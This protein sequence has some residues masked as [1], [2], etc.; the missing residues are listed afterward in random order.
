MG[1]NKRGVVYIKKKHSIWAGVLIGIGGCANLYSPIKLLGAT[2]FSIGLITVMIENCSLYTGKIGFLRHKSEILILA[3][4]LLGNII[5]ALLIGQL[6][7]PLLFQKANEIMI[8]KL[9]VSWTIWIIR[10]IMCGILIYIAVDM[11]NKYKSL[12]VIVLPVVVFVMCGFEHCIANVFYLSVSKIVSFQSIG[13]IIT[14]IIGNTIGSLIAAVLQNT[15]RK[16]C[17]EI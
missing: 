9:S 10:S 12:L 15:V 5:G 2:L 4:M 6:L 17:N 8:Q 13:F 7:S 14:C 16:G 1:K 3:E 11:F